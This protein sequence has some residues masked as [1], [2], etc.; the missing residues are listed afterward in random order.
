[1]PQHHTQ[2]RSAQTLAVRHRN[3]ATSCNH[4]HDAVMMQHHCPNPSRLAWHMG[5]ANSTPNGLTAQGK[6]PKGHVQTHSAEP[7]AAHNSD[8]APPLLPPQQHVHDTAMPLLPQRPV[9]DAERP[10]P[11]RSCAIS[12]AHRQRRWLTARSPMPLLHCYATPA[13]CHHRPN[14]MHPQC[15]NA[16]TTAPIPS[17]Q[18]GAQAILPACRMEPDRHEGTTR[19]SNATTTLTACAHNTTMLLPLPQSRAISMVLRQC[20]QLAVWSPI[21]MRAQPD[22]AMPWLPQWLVC[23]AEMSLPAALP[24]P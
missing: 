5:D 21:A 14:G 20:H 17:D 13:Q 24:P 8:A 1:M 19:C 3:A 2:G 9:C 10:L 4:H 23:K 18:H 16:A 11:P 12:T 15:N 6:M 7:A 22:A